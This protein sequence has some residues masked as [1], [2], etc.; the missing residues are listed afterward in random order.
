MKLL[1]DYTTK[2]R[3]LQT[4]DLREYVRNYLIHKSVERLLET[5]IQ[6]C[7][8]IGRHL[9]ASEGWRYPE[10]NKEVFRVLADEQVIPRELLARLEDMAGFRNV[11]VH[12]YA[13][14]QH[15]KVYDN[16]KHDLGD[17]DKFA[18]AIVTYLNRPSANEEKPKTARERR[19]TYA[20]RAPKSRKRKTAK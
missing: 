16:L 3:E 2:L 1:D 9:I 6:T 11:L 15:R 20:A 13:E 5:A 8:D 12:E 4:T 10:E 19:A 14:I 18:S 7:L 17:F